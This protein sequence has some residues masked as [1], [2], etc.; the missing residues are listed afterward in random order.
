MYRYN[1]P[2]NTIERT[3]LRERGVYICTYYRHVSHA[4][5]TNLRAFNWLERDGRRGECAS[6][7]VHRV[8]VKAGARFIQR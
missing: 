7:P 4:L 5:I 6:Y 3:A 8:S 2:R 1:K